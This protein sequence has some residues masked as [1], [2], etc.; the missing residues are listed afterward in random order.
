[1]G[2]PFSNCPLFSIV[3]SMK[4]IG[5]FTIAALAF[6]FYSPVFGQSDHSDREH[7]GQEIGQKFYGTIV[8]YTS[9]SNSEIVKV[10]IDGSYKGSIGSKYWPSGEPRCGQDG[11][12]CYQS[13]E[14][15]QFTVKLVGPSGTVEFKDNTVGGNSSPFDCARYF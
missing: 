10:Y 3:F 4:S 7:G 5:I 11:S 9:N 15:R 13:R 8:F 1:M 6:L 2:M 12:I 14:D